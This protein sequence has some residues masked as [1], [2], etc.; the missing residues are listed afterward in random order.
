M[1]TQGREGFYLQEISTREEREEAKEAQ[2]EVGPTTVVFLA[3][4]GA[5]FFAC[6]ALSCYLIYGLRH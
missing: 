5:L 2:D 3:L 1:E 6:G 4:I